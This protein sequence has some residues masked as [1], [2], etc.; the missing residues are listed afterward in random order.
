MTHSLRWHIQIWHTLLLALIVGTLLTAY[1]QRQRTLTLQRIER[2][3][4]A[5]SPMLMHASRSLI[6]PDARRERGRERPGP[7]HKPR[8]L[9]R[10]QQ[11]RPPRHQ[12]RPRDSDLSSSPDTLEDV[13][14]SLE[15]RGIYIIIH[16]R[17]RLIITSDD[18]PEARI[19]L[20]RPR[21][22]RREPTLLFKDSPYWE[23][24][25][26]T[27]NGL[28]IITGK[29]MTSTYAYLSRLAFRL[30]GLGLA[31]VILGFAVG[32]FLTG[33]SLRT[34]H[35]ISRTAQEITNG[36]LSQRIEVSHSAS[37]LGTL[38]NIL[39]HSFEKLEASIKQQQR[40]T[41][42]ASHEMRTPLSVILAEGELALESPDDHAA[43]HAALQTCVKSAQHMHRLINSLLDLA[44]LDAGEFQLYPEH[45]DLSEI[46]EESVELLTPLANERDIII[47]NDLAPTHFRFDVNRM[48]QV[49]I[50]LLSNSIKYNTDGGSI[51]I[52]TSLSNKV[53]TLH[54]SNTG[55]IIP[56]A[57]LPY[58]FDR[59]YRHSAAR[60]SRERS[61]GLGLAITKAIIVAHSG[62]IHA[63]ITAEGHT[64]FVVELP[65]SV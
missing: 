51:S 64:A 57:D 37:E 45:D 8:S 11:D 61:T 56:A 10:G 29:D 42:D 41:A 21:P 3:L 60:S 24:I 48:R 23:S 40:F 62:T 14:E 63:E 35:Q 32:W 22:E 38:A 47:R 52:R 25:F 43:Q 27:P 15:S 5:H 31:I 59:F 20:V 36:D 49:I 50:N 58:V 17:D 4:G 55:Q 53:A 6:G 65:T 18:A 30:S 2:D 54:V 7:R 28:R 19:T 46:V 1:Y 39:N 9:A 44:R 13:I 16:H 26:R 34:I 12:L 33:R